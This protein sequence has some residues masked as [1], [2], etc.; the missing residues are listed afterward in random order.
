MNTIIFFFPTRNFFSWP[1]TSF[2][3]PWVA[4]VIESPYART[5]PLG[6]PSEEA[7][8]DRGGSRMNCQIRQAVDADTQAISDVAVA[9]FGDVQGQ[10][11]ADLV[12]GLLKDSSARP[13]LSLVA[14]SSD[15][16]TGHILFTGARVKH[17]RRMVFSSLLAPLSVHPDYQSQGI[18]GQ[19]IKE[20][21]LQLTILGVELVF[22][23]GHPDCYP[24]YE[25]MVVRSGTVGIDSASATEMP[26]RNPPQ[27]IIEITPG[28]PSGK[29]EILRLLKP[30]CRPGP[31]Q[32]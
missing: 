3:N 1:C 26:P 8:G 29:A 20:G 17:S 5:T 2:C 7:V 6:R 32:G 12:T 22:V 9:A 24:Q 15:Q 31:V 13:S 4:W 16:V 30:G 18:G 11:M 14:V 10:E 23:P 25:M 27:V 28:L 21:L 19:F